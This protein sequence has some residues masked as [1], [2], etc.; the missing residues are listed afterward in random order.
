MRKVL[1][2]LFAYREALKHFSHAN[3]TV[4][5]KRTWLGYFWWLLDPLLFMGIYILLVQVI[6]Q[7]GGPDYPVFILLALLPWRWFSSTIGDAASSIVGKAG[8]IKEVR[9]PKI[10]LPLSSVITNCVTFCF[11]LIV[12]AAFLVIFSVPLRWTFLFFP[13][14]ILVQLAFTAG[15]ALVVAHLN[16]YFRDLGNILRYL[17]QIWFFLS[18]GIYAASLVP[19]RFQWLYNLNPFAVLFNAYRDVMLQGA[20]PGLLSLLYVLALSAILILFGVWLINKYEGDYA[21][22]L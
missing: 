2:D 12:L 9:F 10:I 13:A 20:V 22:V 11:G 16:V 1:K 17:L 15:F 14:I 3:L 21:K 18:P 6:F 5:H 4:R 8:V 19:E 7:R